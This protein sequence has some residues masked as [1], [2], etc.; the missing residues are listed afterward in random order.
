MD[1]RWQTSASRVFVK[2]FELNRKTIYVWGSYVL[3]DSRFLHMTVAQT[4]EAATCAKGWSYVDTCRFEAG[5]F[6][7]NIQELC[8]QFATHDIVF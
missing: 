8:L 7:R 6:G 1:T 3:R 2:V 4:A 5:R